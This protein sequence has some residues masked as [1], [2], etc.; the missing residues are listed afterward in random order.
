[1]HSYPFY[2]HTHINFKKFLKITS[3]L[4]IYL[5]IVDVLFISIVYLVKMSLHVLSVFC[6]FLCMN[7]LTDIKKRC[8]NLIID[9][10]K[11]YSLLLLF[12]LLRLTVLKIFLFSLG[13]VYVCCTLYK[14]LFFIESFP[15]FMRINLKRSPIQFTCT[16]EEKW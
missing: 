15:L 10:K 9:I 13:K 1:L 14:H 11:R 8:T 7:L 6:F 5:P 2:I 16:R 4:S 3:I 12:C